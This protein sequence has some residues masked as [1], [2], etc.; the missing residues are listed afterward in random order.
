MKKER[1]VILTSPKN[2]TVNSISQRKADEMSQI[3]QNSNLV[4]LE[5]LL[6]R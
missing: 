5:K 3:L 4:Q 6:N 2:D 1:K